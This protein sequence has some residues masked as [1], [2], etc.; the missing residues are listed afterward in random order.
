MKQVLTFITFLIF[1]TSIHAKDNNIFTPVSD[2]FL[3]VSNVEHT[4]MCACVDDSFLV[5]EHGEVWTIDD[6]IN[7]VKPSDFVR[8]NYFSVINS[9]MVGNVAFINY[10]N[11]ANIKN[12]EKSIDLYWLESAVVSKVGDKWLL[13]QMHST[14]LP[15]GE[16]PKGVTFIKQ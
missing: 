7:V 1:S 15:Q 3:A 4:Q 9:R 13:S 16:I 5:L 14:R 10:W 8:T 11:K 6:F 2:L 12:T